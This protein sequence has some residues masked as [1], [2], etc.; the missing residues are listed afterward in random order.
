MECVLDT[1]VRI[2]KVSFPLMRID[3]TMSVFW[4][5]SKRNEV[6]PDNAATTPM[7]PEVLDAMIPHMKENFGNPSSRMRL[8][9]KRKRPSKRP[10]KQLPDI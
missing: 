6:Y 1:A 4:K 3:P 7:D 2:P 5:N 10:E 9:E 8:E